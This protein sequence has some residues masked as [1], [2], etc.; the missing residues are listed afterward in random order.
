MPFEWM[1]LK[2]YFGV[3]DIYRRQ[4]GAIKLTVMENN[5]GYHAGIGIFAV[6]AEHVIAEAIYNEAVFVLLDCL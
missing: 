3:Q 5:A 2:N 1:W 6:W 4:F